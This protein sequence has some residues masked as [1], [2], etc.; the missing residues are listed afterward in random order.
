MST[1]TT[2]LARAGAAAEDGDR[3]PSQAGVIE[4]ANPSV[5]NPKDP[6]IIFIIQVSSYHQLLV[7]R[8]QLTASSYHV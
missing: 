4:G 7:R 8:A 2:L 5:Y 6:I 3:A 1:L